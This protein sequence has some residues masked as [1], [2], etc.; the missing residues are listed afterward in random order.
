MTA[1]GPTKKSFG[2]PV[3]TPLPSTNGYCCA[4]LIADIT[5]NDEC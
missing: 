3:G 1:S 4:I 2:I 5:K